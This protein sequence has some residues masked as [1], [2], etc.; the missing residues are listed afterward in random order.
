MMLLLPVIVLGETATRSPYRLW[1][2]VTCFSD[3]YAAVC[4]ITISYIGQRHDQFQCS[5]SDFTVFYC[6][7]RSDY[8]QVL[9][10]CVSALCTCTCE[11]EI[12]ALRQSGRHFADDIFVC[13]LNENYL[14]FGWHFEFSY[15]RSSWQVTISCLGNGLVL[16]R[17]QT[18]S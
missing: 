8:Q 11:G 16:H 10:E 18:I 6:I 9:L 13:I 1:C 14:N 4:S 5:K 12:I 17:C 15:L 3:R 2:N 7:S